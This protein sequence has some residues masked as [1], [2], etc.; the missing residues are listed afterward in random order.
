MQ[1]FFNN[2][3]EIN[4]GIST[5]G[6]WRV[7]KEN[8]LRSLNSVEYYYRDRVFSVKSNH[9]LCKLLNTLAI[10]YNLSLDRYYLN[11]VSRANIQYSMAMKMTSSIYRGTLFNGV[12]YGSNTP[13]I[14]LSDNSHFSPYEVHNN[15]KTAKSVNVVKHCKSDLDILLPNGRDTSSETGLCVI[16]VN[17][18]MLAVQYRAFLLEQSLKGQDQNILTTANFVHMYVLPN[19]LSSHLDLCLFNRFSNMV[20]GKPNGEVYKKHPFAL[21]SFEFHVDKILYKIYKE[22]KDKNIEYKQVLKTIPAITKNDSEEVLIIPENAT[23]RQFVWAEILSRIDCIDM[24]TNLDGVVNSNKNQTNNNYFLRTLR[25]ADRD[26]AL[27]GILPL[28]L[29]S[30]YKDKLKTIIDKIK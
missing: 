24:L 19:M 1:S 14:I 22:I 15:W 4:Y 27:S 6:E 16:S 12:F 2:P 29:E 20:Y 5:P 18:A 21:P 30:E 3:S 11:I 9:F 23:T 26:N 17:I 28:N 7:Q 25:Y 13:E 8:L 10:P